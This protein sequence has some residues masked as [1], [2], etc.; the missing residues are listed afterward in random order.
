M[1]ALKGAIKWGVGGGGVAVA[2]DSAVGLIS[3]GL[4]SASFW[5]LAQPVKNS[6]RHSPSFIFRPKAL[7]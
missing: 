1:A 3:T 4:S 6:A 5:T 7:V 2:V